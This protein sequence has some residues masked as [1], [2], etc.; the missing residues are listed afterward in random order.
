MSRSELDTN[1]RVVVDDPQKVVMSMHGATKR[2]YSSL[3]ASIGRPARVADCFLAWEKEL[4]VGILEMTRAEINDAATWRRAHTT[5]VNYVREWFE[6]P[7]S[8]EFTVKLR[9]AIRGM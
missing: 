2:F 9:R 5:A 8:F 1:L 6:I 3:E 7:A 4:R